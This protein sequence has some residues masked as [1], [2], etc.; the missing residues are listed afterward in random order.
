MKSYELKQLARSILRE[1]ETS[2]EEIARM[3]GYVYDPK[4]AERL[5]RLYNNKIEKI[6]HQKLAHFQDKYIKS[7]NMATEKALQE[8]LPPLQV[9]G[10][11]LSRFEF[12]TS[13][14]KN[15]SFDELAEKYQKAIR[16]GN[17]E[18]VFFVENQLINHENTKSHK[19]KLEKLI[20]EHRKNRVKKST[21]RE[22]KDLQE[23]YGFYLQSVEFTRNKGLDFL[24]IQKLFDAL[25]LHFNVPLKK[26]LAS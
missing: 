1:M 18:F 11:R 10:S 16:E 12:W 8:I 24:K 2:L 5:E 23:L 21:Q 9:T 19:E 20:K 22:V 14:Y 13:L 25:N 3:T 4:Q 7:L 17:R 6:I 26:L 15:K